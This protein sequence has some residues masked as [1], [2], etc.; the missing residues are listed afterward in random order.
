M[1]GLTTFESYSITHD[2]GDKEMILEVLPHLLPTF[3]L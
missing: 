1:F 2:D 3:T